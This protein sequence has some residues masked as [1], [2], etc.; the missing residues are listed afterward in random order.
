MTRRSSLLSTCSN[1]SAGSDTDHSLVCRRI[2]LQPKKLNRTKQSGHPRINTAR[3]FDSER[4]RKFLSEVEKTLED[5]QG[6]DATSRWNFMWEAIYSLA[7]FACHVTSRMSCHD[8][9]NA[10]GVSY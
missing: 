5:P 4:Q 9:F 2:I 8:W 10:H 3:T 7:M 6:Q 1:H